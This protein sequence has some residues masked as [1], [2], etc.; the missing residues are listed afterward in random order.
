MTLVYTTYSI[1]WNRRRLLNKSSLNFH[2]T[3]LIHF[4]INLGI[5]VIFKN[6]FH[7]HSQKKIWFLNK[8]RS[9]TFGYSRVIPIFYEAC[10]LYKTTPTNYSCNHVLF[11]VESAVWPLT[12]VVL[13]ANFLETIVHW[14][15]EPVPIA[16]ISIALWNGWMLNK[17][18]IYAQCAVKIGNLK[19]RRNNNWF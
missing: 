3:I 4:Y 2:I 7:Q 18:N 1:L 13:I 8:R 5:V 10:V 11:S 6:F 15:G 12:G 17:P 16:S 14:S 9:T 19:N